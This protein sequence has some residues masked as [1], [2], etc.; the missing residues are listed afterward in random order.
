[1]SKIGLLNRALWAHRSVRAT[2]YLFVAFALIPVLNIVDPRMALGQANCDP[3]LSVQGWTGTFSQSD[4]GSG[5]DTAGGY[6]TVTVQSTITGGTIT[7]DQPPSTCD[8]SLQWNGTLSF[9]VDDFREIRVAVCFNGS[10]AVTTYRLKGTFSVPGYLNIN[11]DAQPNLTW[12]VQGYTTTN[13]EVE[14]VDCV[15]GNRRTLY[16]QMQLF[17]RVGHFPFPDSI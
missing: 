7:L 1:M 11:I 17:K 16:R 9:T 10:E 3:W 2:V 14:S 5:T 4:T 15:G 12:F 13:Y 8:Y 6:T